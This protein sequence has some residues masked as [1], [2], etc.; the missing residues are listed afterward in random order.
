[1]SS[2]PVVTECIFFDLD[3]RLLMEDFADFDLRPMVVDVGILLT[4]YST[5]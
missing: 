1:M 3:P 4:L 5:L 2:M